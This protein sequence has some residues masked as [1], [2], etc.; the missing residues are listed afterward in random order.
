M[1]A[2]VNAFISSLMSMT[3]SQ[4]SAA[5]TKSKH[6]LKGT[7]KRRRQEVLRQRVDGRGN[8]I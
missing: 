7:R 8:I 1:L 5:N 4:G 6:Q 2:A 3:R